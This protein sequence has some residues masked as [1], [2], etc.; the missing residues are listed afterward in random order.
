VSRILVAS[1]SVGAI[2]TGFTLLAFVLPLTGGPFA[3]IPL[4]GLIAA[5]TVGGRISRSA[6]AVVTTVA[7]SVAIVLLAMLLSGSPDRRTMLL[8]AG[9]IATLVTMGHFTALLLRRPAIPA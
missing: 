8:A 6:P 2:V 3:L 9:T 5:G 7:V 4:V 1:L